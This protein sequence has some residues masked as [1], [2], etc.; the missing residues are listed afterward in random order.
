MSVKERVGYPK[1]G[2]PKF[3]YPVCIITVINT[4]GAITCTYVEVDAPD[5]FIFFNEKKE[6]P[7]ITPKNE[8]GWVYL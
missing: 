7:S 2:Y 5:F 6:W 4:F 1:F 8:L 3:G